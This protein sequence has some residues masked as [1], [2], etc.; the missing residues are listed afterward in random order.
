MKGDGYIYI[1]GSEFGFK[2]GLA[3]NYISRF[4]SIQTA[5]PVDL[6]LKRAFLVHNMEIVEKNLHQLF[7]KKH[8]RGEWF[9]LNDNDLNTIEK[10][11]TLNN[12]L[13]MQVDLRRKRFNYI[14]TQ[15]RLEGIDEI[16]SIN[17]IVLQT[18]INNLK[19]EN[20]KLQDEIN[21][22]KLKSKFQRDDI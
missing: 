21:R 6:E 18:Q 22:L 17:E 8:L 10:Y 15:Q 1:I 9:D 7:K 14:D 3:T 5:S 2:I 11:L 19:I 20:Q 16:K 4:S 12:F 13:V